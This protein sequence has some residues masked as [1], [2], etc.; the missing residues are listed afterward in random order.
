[1]PVG[2]HVYVLVSGERAV[3]IVTGFIKRRVTLEVAFR[4]AGQ[5]HAVRFT[6]LPDSLIP[7]GTVLLSCLEL[8]CTKP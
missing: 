8:E 6:R 5:C 2:V 1:M 3:E 7:V 4:S